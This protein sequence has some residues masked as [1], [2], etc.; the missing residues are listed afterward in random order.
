MKTIFLSLVAIVSLY[1]S[2]SK[3]FAAPNER[4]SVLQCAAG[5][6]S[7]FDQTVT[8][9][10]GLANYKGQQYQ[11]DVYPQEHADVWLFRLANS[12]EWVDLLCPRDIYAY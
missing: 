8:F 4:T 11:F 3:A 12:V 9:E 5:E 10:N 1:A 2:A 6:N 7:A